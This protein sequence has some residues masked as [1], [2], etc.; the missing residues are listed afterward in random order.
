MIWLCHFV[1]N[2]MLEDSPSGTSAC[3]VQHLCRFL[4]DEAIAY[5]LALYARVA[6]GALTPSYFQ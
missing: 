4:V 3:Q 6:A 5:L 2:E 1:F